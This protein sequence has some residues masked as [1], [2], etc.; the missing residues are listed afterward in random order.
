MRYKVIRHLVMYDS[1]TTLVG[2]FNELASAESRA[3]KA[4]EAMRNEREIGYV[5]VRDDRKKL[6]VM[7][8]F[9]DGLIKTEQ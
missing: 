9:S 1:L 7:A 4:I 8:E 5:I 2:Q 6:I 3:R